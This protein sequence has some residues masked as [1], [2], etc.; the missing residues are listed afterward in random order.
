MERLLYWSNSALLVCLLA[1]IGSTA[2]AYPLADTLP[3]GAQ[4]TAH[5][6]ILLFATGIKLAYVARIISLKALRRPVH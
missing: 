4:I 3:M 5:I 1:L 2:L 6:A